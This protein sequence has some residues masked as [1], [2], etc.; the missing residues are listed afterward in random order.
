MASPEV[1]DFAK[2]LAPI[3]G[4]NP[5]G[6]PLREQVSHDSIYYKLKDARSAARAAEWSLLFSDE[7]GAAQQQPDWRP[8]LQSAPKV[9]AEQSKDLEVTGWLIEALAREHGFA[10]LRDGFRLARGLVEG[11][12]DGLYPLP[13]EEGMS[14]RVAP[15]AA[16]NGVD[17]DGVL[18]A[19]ILSAPITQV[20]GRGAVSVQDYRQALEVDRIEDPDKRAQRIAQGV[21]T[22]DQVREAVRATSAE[23]FRNLLEDIDG[24]AEE[25]NHLS[26]ELDERCGLGP[27]GVPASPPSSNIRNTLQTCRESVGQIA[28]DVLG[29]AE[30]SG[31]GAVA[32]ATEAGKAVT[33]GGKI[34]SR[35]AAFR[36]LLQVAEFFRRTEPHSPVSYA[37]EQAVRWGRM[38]L[39]ELW[40]ELFPDEG[41][42]G[43]AFKWLGIR[44]KSE[45]GGTE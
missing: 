10:G 24:C 32:E 23:F 15:L 2:L 40:S 22:M 44:P 3:L 43:Q 38:S 1:L 39:P 26:R 41:T 37:L 28:R 8:I 36:M 17:G 25:W 19:P 30:A 6:K 16:L 4:E 7:S 18:I 20:G 12:W 14:T 35:E 31:A 33:A 42:R 29:G 13:D 21:A 11:F 9:L 5:A 27:D 34:Q 45:S